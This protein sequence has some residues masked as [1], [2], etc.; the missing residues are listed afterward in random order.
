MQSRP[1]ESPQCNAKN[2]NVTHDATSIAPH[3]HPRQGPIEA[4]SLVG[5][6]NPS[7]IQQSFLPG[8]LSLSM[9]GTYWRSVEPSLVARSCV[10][11]PNCHISAAENFNQRSCRLCSLLR[12]NVEVRLCVDRN[13]VSSSCFWGSGL[14]RCCT[15]TG[16]FSRPLLGS[17][18]QIRWHCRCCYIAVEDWSSAPEKRAF[19]PGS[20]CC[21]A[22]ST[23]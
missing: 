21:H 9:G 14:F 1:L 13:V 22:V 19:L 4:A 3:P 6:R 2:Y 20:W 17:L 8:I 15:G 10:K 16:A 7:H 12:P 23:G 5:V 18:W 11:R